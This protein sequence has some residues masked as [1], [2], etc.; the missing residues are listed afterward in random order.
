MEDVVVWAEGNHRT[1]TIEKR[2]N[3]ANGELSCM[4]KA[5]RLRAGCAQY[6]RAPARFN[7]PTDACIVGR[8]RSR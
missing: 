1:L 5:H 7:K 4:V 2:G 3:T 8:A 6:E